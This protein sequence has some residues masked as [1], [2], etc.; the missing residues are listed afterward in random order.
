MN[1]SAKALSHLGRP[2]VFNNFGSAIL[3]TESTKALMVLAATHTKMRLG[4]KLLPNKTHKNTSQ[5]WGMDWM[6]FPHLSGEGC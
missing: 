4:G 6:L 2:M 1:L 5:F 3:A